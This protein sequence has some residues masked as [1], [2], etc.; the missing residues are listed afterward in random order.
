MQPHPHH[1][2]TLPAKRHPSIPAKEVRHGAGLSSPPSSNRPPSPRWGCDKGG[3]VGRLHFYLH[4]NVQDSSSPPPA[5]AVSEKSQQK[6]EGQIQPRA[7]HHNK[8]MARFQSKNCCYTM[9]RD[10]C[11]LNEQRHLTEANTKVG[12][13]E[14]SGGSF[15]AAMLLTEHFNRNYEHTWDK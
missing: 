5:E 15:K 13:S 10:S 12:M 4:L 9:T 6:E 8:N 2:S 1:A 3:H 7:T 14:L 11:K